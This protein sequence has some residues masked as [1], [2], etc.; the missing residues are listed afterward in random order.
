[1][2]ES[3]HSPRLTSC[4][5]LIKIKS[6]KKKRNLYDELTFVE[7][8]VDTFYIGLNENPRGAD[9]PLTAKVI[10]ADTVAKD[11]VRNSGP[12]TTANSSTCSANP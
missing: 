8:H 6:K 4:K 1:M 11:W 9:N 2:S 10:D 5:N 3:E 12:L 7:E